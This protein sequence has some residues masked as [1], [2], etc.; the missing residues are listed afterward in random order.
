MSV[1]GLTLLAC[2]LVTV[3]CADANR[4]KEVT[5][6]PS[7]EVAS[8]DPMVRV[9]PN[10]KVMFRN[11]WLSGALALAVCRGTPAESADLTP[12]MTWLADEA[13]AGRMRT[14]RAGEERESSEVMATATKH[15]PGIKDWCFVVVADI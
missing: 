2:A 3:A 12:F 10:I 13:H 8:C 7:P 14:C 9:E 5:S 11:E 1:R 4:G 6:S 15:L